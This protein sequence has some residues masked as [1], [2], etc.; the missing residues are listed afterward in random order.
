MF[1]DKTSEV[2]THNNVQSSLPLKP[3]DGTHSQ[4][5]F[6]VQQAVNGFSRSEVNQ[7]LTGQLRMGRHESYAG[8][9]WTEVAARKAT[10]KVDEYTV[11]SLLHRRTPG[12]SSLFM[13][14]EIRAGI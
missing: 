10:Q 13:T 12:Q 3:I 2:V 14:G 7:T 8:A 11:T 1:F 5:Q 6:S 4:K 9:H